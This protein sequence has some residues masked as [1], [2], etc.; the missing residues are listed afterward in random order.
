MRDDKLAEKLL[1][2]MDKKFDEISRSVQ[3]E[4]KDT[5]AGLENNIAPVLIDSQ[6][7]SNIPPAL[8]KKNDNSKEMNKIFQSINDS[9]DKIDNNI[10]E[11]CS[12]C[13]R[14][15]EIAKKLDRLREEKEHNLKPI[16][17]KS[18]TH[19]N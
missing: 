1:E 19:Y 7:K 8:Q 16:L 18:D 17:P 3:K 13:D 15:I 10:I 9:L 6:E 11:I 2:M 4:F 12:T 5:P 14:I